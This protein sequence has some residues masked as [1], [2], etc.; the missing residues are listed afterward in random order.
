MIR[1]RGGLS[2]LPCHDLEDK[3]VK[4]ITMTIMPPDTEEVTFCLNFDG[5]A[6]DEY[7]LTMK[8]TC[9]DAGPALMLMPCS[10]GDG[11]RIESEQ[12]EC[13]TREPGYWGTEL[14]DGMGWFEHMGYR[15]VAEESEHGAFIFLLN[16]AAP[17]P[18]EE[19]SRPEEQ[20]AWVGLPADVSAEELIRAV[21]SRIERFELTDAEIN[22]LIELQE[23]HKTEFRKTLPPGKHSYLLSEIRPTKESRQAL[24]AYLNAI[25]ALSER[26]R[27][28]LMCLLYLGRDI[29]YYGFLAG[30]V[31]DFI[32]Y[33]DEWGTKPTNQ[34]RGCVNPDYLVGKPIGKWI[35]AVREAMRD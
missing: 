7:P 16:E 9:D 17:Y 10:D 5:W 35:S 27:H 6:V 31:N 4:K 18:V 30:A 34:L 32:D 21:K 3:N 14:Y 2:G 19:E 1:G 20:K 8:L 11:M 33:A 15:I 12:V 26:K 13:V 22:T 23:R 25:E 28:D 24:E 29:T